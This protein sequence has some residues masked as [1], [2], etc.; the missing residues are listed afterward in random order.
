MTSSTSGDDTSVGWKV[1][2]GY[3][4][5]KYLGVEGGYV[6]LNDMT[7]T[8]TITAPVAGTA[9]TNAASDGWTLAAV[10][11]YP[12]SDKFSVMAKLGGAYVL[13]DIAA[14][15]GTSQE[16]MS[17]DDYQPYYGVGASYALLDNLS[18]RAEWE[19]FETDE[20]DIDLLTAG[21]NLKF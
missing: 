19:R 20:F 5:N 10:G 2:L 14:R 15:T 3:Q 17:A 16:T 8:S 6:N 12:L 4:F 1:D 21:L 18:V 11:S 9:R 13:S 7:L